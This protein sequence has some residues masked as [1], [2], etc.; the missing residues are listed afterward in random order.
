M[1]KDVK[2][3]TLYPAIRGLQFRF[4][5][6]YIN[7][8]ESSSVLKRVIE[9]PSTICDDSGKPRTHAIATALSANEQRFYRYSRAVQYIWKCHELP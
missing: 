7:L 6:Y 1:K 9:K 4:I 2:N 5:F 8:I 3:S